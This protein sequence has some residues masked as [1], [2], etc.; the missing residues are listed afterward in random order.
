MKTVIK[1]RCI[2][3]RW[4]W[5][6]SVE[7]AP[8]YDRRAGQLTT[9]AAVTDVTVNWAINISKPAENDVGNRR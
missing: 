9:A 8:L 3:F 5:L 2:L 1:K 6:F 7:A 4:A